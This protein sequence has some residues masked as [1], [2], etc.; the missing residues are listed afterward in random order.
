[1]KRILTALVLIPI[2]LYL[3]IL[4][5]S[6]VFAALVALVAILCYREYASIAEATAGKLGPAGYAAGVALL[7]LDANGLTFLTVVALIAMSLAMRSEDLSQSLAHAGATLLG[8]VY[9]FGTWKC[10]IL[11]R[12]QNQ[13]WLVFALAINWVGD[14]AAYYV[15][16]T[17]GKHKLAPRVSPAKTW[18]GSAGSIGASMV[19]GYFYLRNLFPETTPAAALALAAVANIAGQ[20]GDLA[21]S[22]LKRGAGVKDSGAILPGHGGLLDRVDSTLFTLPVVY[23]YLLLAR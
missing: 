13:Y 23:V 14:I 3:V 21:E 12:E 1:M 10:A 15:G 17:I 18:E 6:P 4:A 22:A 19:F 8:V 9:I 7:A 20:F 2:V 16:K 5:P 11:L